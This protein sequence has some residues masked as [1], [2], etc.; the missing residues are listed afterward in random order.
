MLLGIGMRFD[1][2]V[3]GKVSAF[4]PNAKIIHI[5]IDPAE[6]GKTI[7]TTVARSATQRSLSELNRAL[8]P[9]PPPASRC[10]CPA[11][12]WARSTP[13][14]ASGPGARLPQRQRGAAPLCGQE[15]YRLS[16][17]PTIIT[18]DVGQ[19]QMWAAQF[20]NRDERNTWLSSGG[21]GAMGFGLP[22]AM[23]AKM[24]RPEATVWAVCGDG[25]FQMSIPELACFVQERIPV[26]ICILN[27]GHL[28]M[29]RQWQDLFHKKNYVATPILSPDFVKL[30]EAYGIPAW[31]VDKPR[32]VAGG[33]RG[34][35]GHRRPGADQLPGG[36]GGERLPHDPGRPDHQGDD[37]VHRPV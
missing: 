2:R 7:K 4:A 22:S 3:T 37:R 17:P 9:A 18:T 36:A 26:K 31:K 19:H 30:G 8:R 29:V 11:S 5:D 23:G 10:S 13:G 6:V 27:N 14:R 24:A 35:A 34:R 15:L 20:F 1:D 16:T 21:L 33:Y 12:G 25:G 28:G 32:D